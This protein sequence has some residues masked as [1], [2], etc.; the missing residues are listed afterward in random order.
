MEMQKQTIHLILILVEQLRMADQT[1]A[2]GKRNVICW[3]TLQLT[4][5]NYVLTHAGLVASVVH[6]MEKTQ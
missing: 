2:N 3:Q 1:P 4:H 6:L 5:A